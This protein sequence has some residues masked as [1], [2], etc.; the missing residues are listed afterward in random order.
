MRV[1]IHVKLM[2]LAGS[3]VQA[4]SKDSNSYVYYS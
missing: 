1:V 3:F 4:L 2:V